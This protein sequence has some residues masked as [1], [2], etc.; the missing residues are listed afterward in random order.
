MI[1]FFGGSFNPPHIGHKIITN[2]AYDEIK[3]DRLIISATPKPPHKKN[4]N[5]LDTK[6]RI[7]FCK[8]TFGDNFEISDIE[9]SL[10]KP[11]YT[12]KTLEHLKVQDDDIFLLIGED[13]LFN[14][15]KWYKYE[16][17]LK[18]SKLLVYPRLGYNTEKSVIP[19]T[20]LNAPII[21]IS[22]TDIRYRVHN[23][24]TIKGMVDESIEEEIKKAYMN[25]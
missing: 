18:I 20:K 23:K 1:I 25:T 3:P 24:K 16:E 21:E 7:F 4:D 17:I 8:K 5:I 2:I 9:Q 19:H 10:S 14:F 12:L 11:S 13:S 6:K 15:H 22:S